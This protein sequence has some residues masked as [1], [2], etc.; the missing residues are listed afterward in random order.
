MIQM[1]NGADKDIRGRKVSIPFMSWLEVKEALGGGKDM[2][3]IPCG[4]NEQHNPNKPTG[5][6]WIFALEST[7]RI[8]EKMDDALVSPLLTVGVAP[9]HMEWPGTITFPRDF[10]KELVKQ[11]VKSLWHHGFK[12][13]VLPNTH[14]RNTLSLKIAQHE[15][16]EEDQE[17]KVVYSMFWSPVMGAGARKIVEEEL[18]MPFEKFDSYHRG[19]F[20]QAA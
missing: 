1:G 2:V 11:V 20:R 5:D 14:G 16:K 4:S 12:R 7:L 13:F 18:G 6:D 3:I 17:T 10:H 15:L 19:A 9:Y 8:A